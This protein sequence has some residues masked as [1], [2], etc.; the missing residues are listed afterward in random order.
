MQD[1]NMISSSDSY[2]SSNSAF[3]PS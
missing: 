2:V 1:A 3:M